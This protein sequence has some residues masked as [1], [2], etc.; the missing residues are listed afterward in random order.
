MIEDNQ[1][2]G[3]T[4]EEDGERVELVVGYHVLMGG[5][6]FWMDRPQ[7][8]E[9]SGLGFGRRLSMIAKGRGMEQAARWIAI[10]LSMRTS[11]EDFRW[12]KQGR[13]GENKQEAEEKV[14]VSHLIVHV[15]W[16]CCNLG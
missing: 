10:Y 5:L 6:G 12:I 15:S 7:K 3:Q 9:E 16:R 13:K 4:T 11:A 8:E 14:V 2:H 1:E